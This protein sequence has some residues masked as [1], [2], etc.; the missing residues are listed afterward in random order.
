MRQNVEMH[1]VADA[2]DSAELLLSKSCFFLPFLS[3]FSNASHFGT[4]VL[5]HAIALHSFVRP[6]GVSQRVAYALDIV[7]FP[8][9]AVFT[10]VSF[11]LPPG[12][13]SDSALPFLVML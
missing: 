4:T 1:R 6:G 9:P 7:A 13:R 12:L 2:L 5:G 11:R 10:L 8:G 3:W